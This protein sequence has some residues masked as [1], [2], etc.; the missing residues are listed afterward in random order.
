MSSSVAA[1]IV[2]VALASLIA[3]GGAH[4]AGGDYGFVGGTTAERAQ[5]TAALS[6]STFDW[7]RVPHRITVH[8]A[9]GLD[10]EATPGDIW[11]DANLLRSGRFA[12]GTIQHEYAHQVD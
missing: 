7:S 12:W 9:P 1:R 2:I 5:V 4:A 10:S 6:R 3:C 8:I 11:L